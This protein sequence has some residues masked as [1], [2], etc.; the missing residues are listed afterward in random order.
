MKFT[1]MSLVAALLIGSSAFA[2]ENTKVS[3]D[4]KLFYET[5]DRG[6]NSFFD[7]DASAADAALNLNVTTDLMKNSTVAVSAGAGYTVLSTLGLENNLVSAVW[8]GAHG[9]TTGTKA[10][11]GSALGGAKVENANW[12]NEAWLAATAG[13][14]TVKIGRMELD[15]PLAFTEKWTIEKNTFEAAV[16]INQDIPDTTLVGAFIGNGN[17]TETY[18]QDNRGVVNTLGLASAPVVNADGK[19]T[20]YAKDGAY[21][22]AVI[23]NS[24]KPLTVQAWYYDLTRLANAYWLQADLDASQLGVKGMIAGVQYASVSAKTGNY[25]GAPTDASTTY[26]VM[27]GYDIKDI[28]TVKVAYSSVN[29]KGA[30][31]AANTATSSGYSKLYT[32]AWWNY[33]QVTMA[34]TTAYNLTIE[35]PVKGIAD[36]ALYYTYADHA[37]SV[38]SQDLTEMTLTAS[39]SFGALDA[40]A[41]YVYYDL[42]KGTDAVN[43]L[44][45][46]LTLNF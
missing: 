32:E 27:L 7:K 9:A 3:G 43:L 15:T 2:I 42:G 26:A 44:Q 13:K 20:T 1:K 14:T 17:G 25:L 35:A 41:A 24:F 8:G 22:V 28:A 19:F 21:A 30:V 45:V 29:D 40:T 11:Y 36:F 23:N 10:A 6:T 46:Y 16:V 4:A 31:T 5:S 18:G 37:K 34:D 33:G 39:K 12:M 38:S